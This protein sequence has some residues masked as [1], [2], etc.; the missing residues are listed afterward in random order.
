[1]AKKFILFTL[2]FWF[3]TFQS[4]SYAQSIE[5]IDEPMIIERSDEEVLDT[6]YVGAFIN[7]FYDLDIVSKSFK[8][9]LWL[10][11]QYRRKELD[12]N[13]KIE[14]AN[15]KEYSINNLSLDKTKGLEWFGFRCRA[16]IMKDWNVQN[17]PFD[18]QELDVVVESQE[19]DTSA[20]ILLPDIKNSSIDNQFKFT[21]WTINSFQ[22]QKINR[23]YNS[24]FGDL[25]ISGNSVYPAVKI[26]LQIKR[27]GSWLMLFKLIT[28]VIIA[29][30]ISS[31][32]FFI[33]PMNT[34]PRFGLCVGGLFAAVGN[35]YIIEG[36]IPA[37][38]SNTLLDNIHNTTFVFIFLI[39]VL[40][41][42]SLRFRESGEEKKENISKKVDKWSFILTSIA[43]YSL[44]LLFI[45]RAY[46]A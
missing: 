9:D 46:N 18:R 10:W 14:I 19:F 44:M 41:I 4:E 1:M 37:S 35:K 43:F 13:G 29:F 5:E 7:S 16:E 36:I 32:V 12:L 39:I 38:S 31:S 20:I 25:E 15:S 3:I 33:N 26:G 23:I 22:M 40:S 34:D 30:L 28:G 2:S 8:T 17:F 27:K 24:T 11:F 21:D 6:V 45:F 42:I